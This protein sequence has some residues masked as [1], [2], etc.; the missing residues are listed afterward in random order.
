MAEIKTVE[1]LKDLIE[2]L[3]SKN[4]TLA[5]IKK[6]RGNNDNFIAYKVKVSNQL[7]NQYIEKLI[8]QEKLKIDLIED[9]EPYNGDNPTNRCIKIHKDN[10]LIS[11]TIHNL[12]S[13]FDTQQLESKQKITLDDKFMGY[14]LISDDNKLVLI[15]KAN[16]ILKIKGF[17]FEGNIE[18]KT[19]ILSNGICGLIYNLQ[20]YIDCIIY[21][22][23]LY[24]ININNTQMI[25][26]LERAVNRVKRESIDKI[27]NSNLF[28]V[29]IAEQTIRDYFSTRKRGIFLNF[30]DERLNSLEIDIFKRC[31][32]CNLLGIPYDNDNKLKIEGKLPAKKLIDYLCKCSVIDIED[33]D[34]QARKPLSANNIKSY[35]EN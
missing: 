33:L 2:K 17:A 30:S 14:A 22:G 23:F 13:V 7:L 25:F 20:L 24:G 34:N 10:E 1:E 31:Q 6:T 11:N 28:P 18:N 8:I 12:I 21:D 29:G 32:V 15:C 5:F 4:W 35:D 3:N 16:P 9:I 26:N 27:V 19:D